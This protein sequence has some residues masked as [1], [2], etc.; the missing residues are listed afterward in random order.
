M[1]F[2]QTKTLAIPQDFAS[3]ALR[4]SPINESSPGWAGAFGLFAC[5]QLCTWKKFHSWK[6]RTG[7]PT[8][9][10]GRL[11]PIPRWTGESST[12]HSD[13]RAL[14]R[15]VMSVLNSLRWVKQVKFIRRDSADLC[16]QHP[17]SPSS[18][19]CKRKFLRFPTMW[20]VR[21]RKNRKFSLRNRNSF[22]T[23]S[24]YFASG[25]GFRFVLDENRKRKIEFSSLSQQTRVIS[26]FSFL[27]GVKTI[28][29][30]CAWIGVH[31]DCV[32][33]ICTKIGGKSPQTAVTA[34]ELRCRE[35][36]ATES[37]RLCEHVSRSRCTSVKVLRNASCVWCDSMWFLEKSSL[38]N[39]IMLQFGLDR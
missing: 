37:Q 34:G 4:R 25:I 27:F 31:C 10:D 36:A 16:L 39:R 15:N 11:R 28:H 3:S 20:T 22:E 12:P 24:H 23:V 19:C 14:F 7:R 8:H 29:K 30:V 9:V 35:S 26:Q 38:P 13:H 17:S 18:H 21:N 33:K 1:T 6:L 32:W 5:T 2:R